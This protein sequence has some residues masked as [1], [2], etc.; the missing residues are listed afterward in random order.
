MLPVSLPAKHPM[1][2][3]RHEVRTEEVNM[4]DSKMFGHRLMVARHD[5][6]MNQ[7]E[8]EA[9][10]G[11]GKGVVTRYENGIITPGLDQAYAMAKVLGVTLD[12]LCPIQRE[13][14]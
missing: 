3:N 4:Y 7:A 11:V 9:A 10:S 5:A 2:A 13:G 6:R 12:D 1:G 8:L 14:V